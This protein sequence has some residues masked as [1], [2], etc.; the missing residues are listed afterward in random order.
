MFR[1][2]SFN[3]RL[4][5]GLCTA[6]SGYYRSDV[7]IRCLQIQVLRK[8]TRAY[9]ASITGRVVTVVVFTSSSFK[10]KAVQGPM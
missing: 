9:V 4:H 3:I 8:G 1:S 10:D 6:T 5:K 7:A 2:S